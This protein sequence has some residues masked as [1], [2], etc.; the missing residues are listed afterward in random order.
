MPCSLCPK[1]NHS[2][3]DEHAR[4]NDACFL[5]RSQS[6][7]HKTPNKLYTQRT[8]CAKRRASSTYSRG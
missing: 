5:L 4:H 8:T 7:F 2:C 3:D 1:P 6:R